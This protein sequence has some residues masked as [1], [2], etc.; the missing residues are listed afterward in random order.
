MFEIGFVFKRKSTNKF[1]KTPLTITMTP[2]CTANK[3]YQYSEIINEKTLEEWVQLAHLINCKHFGWSQNAL[4]VGCYGFDLLAVVIG[5]VH[6]HPSEASGG[7]EAVADLV[8]QGWVENYT[9][10]RDFK[11][12]LA[13]HGLGY[14]KSA[15]P[16]GDANRNT[17]AETEYVDLPE[18]EKV[19]D[20]VIAQFIIDNGLLL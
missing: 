16:I 6:E 7:I 15:K 18:E 1:L 17:L 19:K 5:Y 8:H 14:I 3:R 11:P 12:Y 20:R 10:W 4:N 2:T 13:K 9:Y